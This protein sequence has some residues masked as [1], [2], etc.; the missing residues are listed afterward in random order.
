M[1]IPLPWFYKSL[2]KE[3]TT[4]WNHNV[5]ICNILSLRY[6]FV[7]LT[8]FREAIKSF[9]CKVALGVDSYCI[10][11]VWW[12]CWYVGIDE[13]FYYNVF[14]Q[15]VT[16]GIS[17]TLMSGT[18]GIWRVTEIPKEA[19]IFFH[20]KFWVSIWM[21]WWCLCIFWSCCCWIKEWCCWTKLIIILPFFLH[22]I[23][24]KK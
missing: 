11:E 22:I 9:L 6:I 24:C 21:F 3:V 14:D 7:A 15:L 17:G 8:I 20:I 10:G 5:N 18:S 1:F 13:F 19:R 16:G 2:Y 12:W 23:V 4:Y